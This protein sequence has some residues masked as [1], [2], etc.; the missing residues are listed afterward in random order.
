MYVILSTICSCYEPSFYLQTENTFVATQTCFYFD[1]FKPQL[2]SGTVISMDQ[3]CS[4]PVD[5]PRFGVM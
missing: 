1:Q 4:V 3:A 5:V 2:L